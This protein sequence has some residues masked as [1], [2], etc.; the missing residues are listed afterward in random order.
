GE[1]REASGSE[2]PSL[3]VI[4]RRRAHR[5]GRIDQSDRLPAPRSVPFY[6][7]DCR[8]VIYHPGGIFEELP[9]LPPEALRDPRV[10]SWGNVFSSCSSNETVKRLLRESGGAGVT[11]LI[12]ST[13]QLLTN[14]I[15]L[16][17]VTQENFES[18]NKEIHDGEDEAMKERPLWSL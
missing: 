4:P 2:A 13:E 8:P 18:E 17:R 12:P 15:L 3:V 11:F 6:E 9:S 5:R 14:L 1:D 10:Q 16:T 7:V